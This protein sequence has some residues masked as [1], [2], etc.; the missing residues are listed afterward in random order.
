M[1]EFLDIKD[2][3]NMIADAKSLGIE[4]SFG[5][6]VKSDCTWNRLFAVDLINQ[7]YPSP[8]F[9]EHTCTF[10]TQEELNL[11]RIAGKYKESIDLKFVV[12]PRISLFQRLWRWFKI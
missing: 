6:S 2:V 7:L 10:R 11:Y 12:R 9:H 3:T 4:I 1:S 8:T 5:D